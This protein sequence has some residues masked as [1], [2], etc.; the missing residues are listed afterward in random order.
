M[1]QNRRNSMGHFHVPRP[2]TPSDGNYIDF[3]RSQV[4]PN[5]RT[6]HVRWSD[7]MDSFMIT[8][9]VEQVLAG[10][11]RSDNGFTSF[12]VSKAIDKV[13]NGCGV[14]VSNKNVRARLKTLKK[15]YAEV[16]Q[17]LNMSGFGLDPE[18]GR[19][20]ADAVA[21]DKFIKG[22]PKFGKWRTKLCPRYTE[23]ET[24]FGNDT[25]TGER[26]VSGFDHFSPV[27]VTDESVNELDVENVEMG[28]SPVHDHGSVEKERLKRDVE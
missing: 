15:E 22:K 25:A 16:R 11:K 5:A 10:H 7:E 28:P 26:T 17:L 6:R 27:N 18:T 4:E 20:V 3:G 13:L 9:L 8:S 23:M 14:I 2:T 12:Q 1:A 19:I 21:W 24:I